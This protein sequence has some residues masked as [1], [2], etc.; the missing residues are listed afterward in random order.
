MGRGRAES[1][2]FCILSHRDRPFQ[3][4]ASGSN[5]ESQSL[6]LAGPGLGT[7]SPLSPLV[8]CNPLRRQGKSPL[9]N[10]GSGKWSDWHRSQDKD[11][12]H[13][14]RAQHL[15]TNGKTFYSDHTKVSW[16]Q[17]SPRLEY[18]FYFLTSA[19]WVGYYAWCIGPLSTQNSWS[20][21]HRWV[22]TCIRL[23]A[24][25]ESARSPRIH[26]FQSQPASVGTRW[27]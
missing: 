13:K 16:W 18:P 8:L 22:P 6:T 23:G 2:Q 17:E 1:S 7:A 14:D 15:G 10:W 19:V 20:R 21:M 24:L 9:S 27:V 4:A 25:V 11:R 5:N 12:F 3:P 26:L